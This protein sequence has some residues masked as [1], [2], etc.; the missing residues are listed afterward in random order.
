MLAIGGFSDDLEAGVGTWTHESGGAGYVDQW[1]RS[2]EKNHTSGGTW[3]WK[4][5][6]T[7]TGTYADLCHGC[8]MTE[9][10][11]LGETTT[12]RFWHWMEAE[13]SGSYPEHCYDGGL[14]DISVGGGPWTQIIPDGGYT[15]R[16]RTGGTPGPFP[17]ETWVFSGSFGWTEETFTLEGY[18]GQ[19]ARF[20]FRFGSDGSVTREGWYVD[21]V[22]VTGTTPGTSGGGWQPVAV[23]P[24]TL[25]M[26]NAPNPFAAA[27]T[28]AFQLAGEQPVSVKIFDAAGRLVQTLADGIHAAGLHRLGWDG[29]NAAGQRVPSGVYYCRL[30][31]A[32]GR[33]TKSMMLLR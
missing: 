7:G 6:D 2:S 24:A 20:R 10:I 31:T 28:I 14:V 11:A 27:T 25:L 8:L 26:Q 32:D 12:L 15:H 30:Q 5:G 9:E 19:A 3:S 17:A 22:A 23:Q 1:H 16:I 33:H 21:D 29:A 4:Q 13:T 18:G